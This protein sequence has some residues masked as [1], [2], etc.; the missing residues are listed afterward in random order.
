MY[1]FPCIYFL[2]LCFIVISY[3]SPHLCDYLWVN[4]DFA[5]AGVGPFIIWLQVTHA[6]CVP[7]LSLAGSRPPLISLGYSGPLFI[8][9]LASIMETL[10]SFESLTPAARLLPALASNANLR[11]DNKSLSSPTRENGP[12]RRSFSRQPGGKSCNTRRNNTSNTSSSNSNKNGKPAN[13]RLVTCCYT[14]DK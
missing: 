14:A 2:F 9:P 1:I 7:L 12:T 3:Y 6:Q 10:T 4:S 8:A 11:P 13:Y 5:V